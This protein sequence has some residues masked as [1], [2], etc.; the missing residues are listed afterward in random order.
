[1]KMKKAY[2]THFNKILQNKTVKKG[3]MLKR[4]KSS[5]QNLNKKKVK[6]NS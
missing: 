4:K 2:K 5:N 1:M 6:N 3:F